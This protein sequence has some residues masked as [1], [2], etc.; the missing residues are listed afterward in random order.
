MGIF[1]YDLSTEGYFSCGMEWYIIGD[2]W[3]KVGSAVFLFNNSFLMYSRA[4]VSPFYEIEYVDIDDS[5]DG[6]PFGGHTR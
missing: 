5:G 6:A 4:V 1:L 3:E 2:K